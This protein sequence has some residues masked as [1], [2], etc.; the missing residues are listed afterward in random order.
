MKNRWVRFLGLVAVLLA[1]FAIAS[2]AFADDDSKEKTEKEKDKDKDKGDKKRAPEIDPA[3][4]G[5]AAALLLG[6]ALLLQARRSSRLRR[7]G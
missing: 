3:G 2:P 5:S 6:G 7:A 1:G 4:V